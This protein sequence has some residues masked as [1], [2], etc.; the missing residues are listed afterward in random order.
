MTRMW[1]ESN[2]NM[3]WRGTEEGEYRKCVRPR[4]GG[5][6]VIAIRVRQENVKQGRGDENVAGGKKLDGNIH[7]RI[8][9]QRYIPPL[10]E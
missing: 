5:L 7:L 6:R 1:V 9:P 10:A 2:N 8:H 3:T 4:K